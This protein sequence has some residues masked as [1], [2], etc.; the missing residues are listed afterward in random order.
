M[1]V[2]CLRPRADYTDPGRLTNLPVPGTAVEP[3]AGAGTARPGIEL[4]K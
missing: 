4:G 1:L 2:P 3:G